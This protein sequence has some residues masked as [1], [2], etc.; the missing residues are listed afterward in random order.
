MYLCQ[1]LTWYK[2]LP[3]HLEKNFVFGKENFPSAN[4]NKCCTVS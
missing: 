3:C 2:Q 1:G 4:E